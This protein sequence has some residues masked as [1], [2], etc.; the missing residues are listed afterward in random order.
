VFE[1]DENKNR[2]NKTKHNLSFEIAI[3]AFDDS[4]ALF[5]FNSTAGGEARYQVTGRIDGGQLV[6]V[7]V[8]TIRETNGKEKY[9]IIS[10]RKASAGERQR[11]AEAA[12]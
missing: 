7:V 12:Y 4:C 3:R 2:A 9:R 6:I 11:Y 8:Y 1:W 10:A 5:E